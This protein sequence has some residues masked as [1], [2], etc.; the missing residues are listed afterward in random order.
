MTGALAAA[1]IVLVGSAV[2][3]VAVAWVA[4]TCRRCGRHYYAW[5]DYCRRCRRVIGR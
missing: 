4:L 5:G 2:M 1:G 3:Y